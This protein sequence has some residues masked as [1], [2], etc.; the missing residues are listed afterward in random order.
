MAP[1]ISYSIRA[2]LLVSSMNSHETGQ[3]DEELAMALYHRDLARAE[4]LLD[5]GARINRVIERTDTLDREIVDDTTTYLIQAAVAGDVETAKFLLD[6]G[7]DPNIAG[8]FTGRTALLAAA[9]YGHGAIVDLLLAH[10]ANVEGIDS[11]SKQ[12]ALAYAT[13][14]VNAPIVRSLLNAGARGSFRRLG[15]SIDGDEAAREVVR[16]LVEHGAN[17]NEIDDWGRTPLMW[18]ALYATAETVQYMLELGADVN[19]VSEANMNGIRSNETALALAGERG[20]C[21]ESAVA[22]LLSHGAREV[23]LLR[24]TTEHFVTRVWR[25]WTA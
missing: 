19:R 23:P 14:S 17:I 2:A 5:G 24:R 25:K 13:G 3:R 9:T 11:Y 15:F 7:A 1:Q 12:S 22:V 21:C 16:L 4:E 20:R 10:G 8:S 6:R 18:A